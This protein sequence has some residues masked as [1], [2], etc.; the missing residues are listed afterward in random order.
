MNSI[1]NLNIKENATILL[2]S[3]MNTEP[4]KHNIQS[5]K[6]MLYN[7]LKNSKI[8]CKIKIVS[9][10]ATKEFN[11][12]LLANYDCII[13]DLLDYGNEITINEGQIKGIDNYIKN[14]GSIIV[15]HD[16]PFFGF[17]DI[18]G[19]TYTKDKARCYTEVINVSFDHEIW[20]SYF[21]LENLKIIKVNT[22]S[23]CKIENFNETKQLMHSYDNYNDL[24]LSVRH[25]GM[26]KAIFWNAGHSPDLTE[27][28]KKLYLNIV[29]FAL[30][31]DS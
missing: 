17:F 16:H 22:H 4:S 20:T 25:I 6:E 11:E 14:G 24:Y 15:T 30:K 13:Y 18:L 7:I 19:L 8:K 31:D 23:G 26:G 3:N 10:E 29:A 1:N 27:D 21:N 28:E 5:K 9:I 12:M 2:I